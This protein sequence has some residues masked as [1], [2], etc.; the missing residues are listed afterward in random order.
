[1]LSKNMGQ[2]KRDFDLWFPSEGER[3]RAR[4]GYRFAT[5]RYEEM[6]AAGVL[7]RPPRKNKHRPDVMAGL[8]KEFWPEKY[9]S[10]H[11]FPIFECWVKALP[12]EHVKEKNC[13]RDRTRNGPDMNKYDTAVYLEK[14]KVELRPEIV[15]AFRLFLSENPNSAP[16][17]WLNFLGPR[18]GFNHHQGYC[19]RWLLWPKNE[20]FLARWLAGEDLD[21]LYTEGR[22]RLS[23]K[24]AP[25]KRTATAP[26]ALPEIKGLRQ[27][28]IHGRM[29]DQNWDSEWLDLMTNRFEKAFARLMWAFNAGRGSERAVALAVTAV[30]SGSFEKGWPDWV[31]FFPEIPEPEL[32]RMT[33]YFIK[34]LTNKFITNQK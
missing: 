12:P 17:G 27:P 22:R 8:F 24:K 7:S 13:D 11:Y 9:I 10:G 31:A 15:T 2:Y 33:Q 34:D 26:A 30:L 14:T 25:V 6:R 23:S 16:T 5:R 20:A 21:L 1:M 29:V 3:L 28:I 18:Y 32:K 4:E 19:F